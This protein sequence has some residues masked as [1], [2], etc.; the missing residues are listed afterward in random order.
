GKG[1][2]IGLLKVGWKHLFL[3]D[4]QDKVRQV[5]PL[6]V[7]DFF[8][9]PDYQR[10]GYGKV[11]FDHMLKTDT[12]M[13]DKIIAYSSHILWITSTAATPETTTPHLTEKD[14]KIII[15]P[16]KPTVD[17]GHQLRL[18]L[19]GCQK[20][21]ER[22]SSLQVEPVSETPA[23]ALSPA[24]STNSRRDSQLTER[25]YFDVKFYHNKLW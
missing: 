3:F 18:Q 4:E 1:E 7:L 2:L 6:C 13:H 20:S 22:P 24:G 25:G 14:N 23:P 9:L 16:I 5:E 19:A 12:K 8:V 17:S 10:H 15:E 11:L 21:P